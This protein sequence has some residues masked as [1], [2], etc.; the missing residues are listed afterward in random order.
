MKFPKQLIFESARTVRDVL[1][2][3]AIEI[4]SRIGPDRRSADDRDWW[5][6]RRWLITMADL[7]QVPSFP[8]HLRRPSHGGGPDFIMRFPDL[9]NGD[10]GIEVT[11][12]TC[13]EDQIERTRSE[14]AEIGLYEMGQFGGRSYEAAPRSLII[15]D[16][17][18]HIFNAIDRKLAKAD[19]YFE[20]C[21]VLDLL[22]Y[23]N[24]NAATYVALSE[25][26]A[27]IAAGADT[28][29]AGSGNAHRIGRVA[30]LDHVEF[31][32][33]MDGEYRVHRTSAA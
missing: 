19:A 10:I 1:G 9:N 20:A 21:H 25:V 13:R 14:K 27:I 24:N 11:E 28:R 16:Y 7:G 3:T 6:F 15:E 17:V 12:A 5:C 29:V 32:M 30:V 22:I 31:G 26:A 8:C 2:D 4:P 33:F 18:D 23:V